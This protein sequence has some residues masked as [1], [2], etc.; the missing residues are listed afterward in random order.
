VFRFSQRSISNLEGCVDELQYIAYEAIKHVDFTVIEGH[1]TLERQLQLY[2]DGFT[3]LKDGSKHNKFPSQAFDFIP[4]PFTDWHDKGRFMEVANVLKEL[5]RDIKA[6]I[7]WGGD[8]KS[9]VDLP[10]IQVNK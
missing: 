8:W 3:T 9:F 7:T 6:D 10:H 2:N 1:R 5:A 4:H